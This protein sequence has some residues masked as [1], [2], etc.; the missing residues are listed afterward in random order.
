MIVV[1]TAGVAAA[2]FLFAQ[3]TSAQS[4]YNYAPYNQ[5]GGVGTTWRPSAQQRLYGLQGINPSSP[6]APALRDI[7]DQVA[8]LLNGLNGVGVYV[9]REMYGF[10]GVPF[11]QMYGTGRYGGL[12]GSDRPYYGYRR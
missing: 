8:G 2:M 9:P 5:Y 7:D 1:K 12:Y 10:Q 11:D 3:S 4:Y 6:I